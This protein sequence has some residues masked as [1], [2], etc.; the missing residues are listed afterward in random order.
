MRAAQPVAHM[1]PPPR[2]PK[3]SAEGLGAY[4]GKVF[5]GHW[6]FWTYSAPLW[7]TLWL[8]LIEDQR[9]I[10]ALMLAVLLWFLGTVAL[11]IPLAAAILALTSALFVGAGL[12]P[13]QR[14]VA[15]QHDIVERA[16][17]AQAATHPATAPTPTRPAPQ[18]VHWIWPLLL[19]LWIG[20]AW[21]KDD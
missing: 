20:H 12:T 21:G 10:V 3:W 5:E 17:R 7:I 16:A 1:P 9:F 11:L 4:I 14:Q 15:V 2:P 8:W 19:G 6:W 13:L 18:R